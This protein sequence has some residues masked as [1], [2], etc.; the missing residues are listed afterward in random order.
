[1]DPTE[2]KPAGWYPSSR[3][4]GMERYWNGDFWTGDYRPAEELQGQFGIAPNEPDPAPLNEDAPADDVWSALDKVKPAERGEA[5]VFAPGVRT[6]YSVAGT[7]APPTSGLPA[8]YGYPQQSPQGQYPNAGNPNQALG[9]VGVV[10]A[11]FFPLAGAIIGHV[12]YAKASKT[13]TSKALPLT[14]IILGWAFSVLTLIIWTPFIIAIF[15]GLGNTTDYDEPKDFGDSSYSQPADNLIPN[16]SLS[17]NV[18]EK[19]EKDY[20]AY[21]TWYAYCDNDLELKVGATTECEIYVYP[22]AET[23]ESE[24]FTAT[25]KY[26]SGDTYSQELDVKLDKEPTPVESFPRD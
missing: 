1:M 8:P 16:Y 9:I 19:L 20:P 18:K 2:S 25:V 14:A 21:D 4:P 12:A 6:E 22:F 7:P 23:N 3:T 26:L 5:P 15:G 10:L 13:Q 24:D 11:F 17:Q